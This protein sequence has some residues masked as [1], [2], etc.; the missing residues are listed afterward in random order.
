VSELEKG[1]RLHSFFLKQYWFPLALIV[2]AISFG[3][4]WFSID[5]SSLS[6]GEGEK[7]SVGFI[8]SASVVV[9]NIIFAFVSA[10][11]RWID[12]FPKYM[13]VTIKDDDGKQK[14]LKAQ[15]A[16]IISE[17]DIRAY[18]QSLG[19]LENNNQRLNLNN[20]Y[21]VTH[22]VKL[23]DRQKWYNVIMHHNSEGKSQ[24]S[25]KKDNNGSRVTVENFEAGGKVGIEIT[26]EVRISPESA[27]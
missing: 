16:F 19:Q 8:M 23:W 5:W 21:E 11:G 17:S 12:S 13:N 2:C 1:E 14:D 7:H 25:P 27:S 9:A 6:L 20:H 18:A 24:N 3:V 4:W 26:S 15:N 22:Y 10:W